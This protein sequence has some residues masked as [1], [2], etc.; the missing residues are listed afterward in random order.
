MEFLLYFLASCL[1]ALHVVSFVKLNL[2]VK[3]NFVMAFLRCPQYMSYTDDTISE[4]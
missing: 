2:F 4:S 3:L 1:V